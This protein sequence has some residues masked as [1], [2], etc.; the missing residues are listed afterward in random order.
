M[1]VSMWMTRDIVTIGPATP[2]TEA[3]SIM[4]QRHIR[5]LP[6]VEQYA[7]SHHPVGIITATDILHAYPSHVNPFAVAVSDTQQTHITV[8]EIMSR[9]LQTVTPETPIDEAARIMRN[10]KISTLLVVQ[11]IRLVGLITESDIFRAF[12]SILDS[13][14]GGVSITFEIT[15]EEDIFG[16]LA[17]IALRWG[18]H[19]VSLLSVEQDKRKLCVV[20]ITGEAVDNMLNELWR[21]GHSVLNVLR[22]P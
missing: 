10:M 12:V 17:P 14:P 7:N 1:I 5:R 15:E 9:S 19:I 21:S 20:R 3:A 18:V 2:I 13:R 4:A 11:K 6:V 16:F 8:A 22:S